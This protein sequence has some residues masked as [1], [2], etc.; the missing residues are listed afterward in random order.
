MTRSAA[1]A[2]ATLWLAPIVSAQLPPVPEPP[3]NP[4]TVDKVNLGKVLFWDEQLSSTRTVACGTC[5]RP[6]SA[7]ADPRVAFAVNPGPD[8][9]FG[10][11]D[12]IHGSP[13]VPLNF[14]DGTY[15]KHP[16]FGL[17]VQVT[18]RSAPSTINA[19]FNVDQFWDGRSTGTFRD[20]LTGQVVSPGLASLESQASGPPVGDSEM[21]HQG[22]DW[23]DCA[24]RIQNSAPLALVDET[25]IPAKLNRFIGGNTYPQLFKRV[26]GDPAVTP[27]RIIQAIAAYERVLISDQT[28]FDLGT[29]T[30]H[31]QVGLDLFNNKARC[32]LCHEGVLFRD[33][34]FHNIGLR[35]SSEDLGRYN[36]TKNPDDRGSFKTTGLRNVGLKSA[37]MH[38]GIHTSLSE[39]IEFYDRGGDFFD[40]L[41]PAMKPLNLTVAEK[42]AL[43]DFLQNGLADPRVAYQLPP[44]DP[45]VLF[46]QS[47]NLATHYGQ[48]AAGSGN[49]AIEPRLIFNEP[50]V[51][52]N[53]NFTV[54]LADGFGGGAA[55]LALDPMQGPG[56]PTL[57]VPI[58]IG[59]SAGLVIV[60]LGPLND[61]GAGEGWWSGTFAIPSVPA[62]SKVKLFAQ[63]YVADPGAPLGVS[64]TDGI[65][66]RFFNPR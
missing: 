43:L 27:V 57:G 11:A 12:D 23:V 49:P 22:R 20:P 15:G 3:E 17:D 37:F 50:A 28:P 25:L 8:G 26:F 30:P 62:L 56:L 2:L 54:A 24:T 46:S 16:L 39:V 1:L 47:G 64:G 33:D 19:A 6:S 65:E 36:V 32:H 53:P 35:P 63:A 40:N 55:A 9:M 58:L 21:A 44:F 48:G 29:L 31:Q 10:T 41:D 18:G 60:P 66:L 42:V 51:L 4:T 61:V 59:V 38:N 5:H 14:A 52:G 13:G 45:P 7:G 34:S